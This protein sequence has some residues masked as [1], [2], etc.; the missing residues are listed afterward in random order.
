MEETQKSFARSHLA[1]FPISVAANDWPFPGCRR[2][3]TGQST[4]SL[5]RH[6]CLPGQKFRPKIIDL[7]FDPPE[8]FPASRVPPVMR[9]TWKRV[10][11][12]S[13][14]V[15]APL[16]V[17]W[18]H[19]AKIEAW[20]SWAKH[21]RSVE[22]FPAGPLSADSR[23]TLRLSNGVKSTFRMVEFDPPRHWK[24]AG[25]FLG[26]Q[27]LYDHIFSPTAPGETTI[28]FTVDV[29][30]GPAALIRGIFGRIYRRNLGRAVPLLVEEIEAAAGPKP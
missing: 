27:V 9:K 30:G 18:N 24:W 5:I 1:V 7:L 21:I 25:P 10:V 29:G 2:R 16:E 8:D 20:P 28:R 13:F 22:K 12:R 26:S 3:S 4:G 19:L 6:F 15:R 11:D 23:G 17:A 14:I